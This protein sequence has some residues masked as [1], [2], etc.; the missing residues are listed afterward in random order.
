MSSSHSYLSPGGDRRDNS[1]AYS[2][3]R[4]LG[5][6][7]ETHLLPPQPVTPPLRVEGSDSIPTPS[8]PALLPSF[9]SPAVSRPPTNG[10]TSETEPLLS[11][12]DSRGDPNYGVYLSTNT[13][14][15]SRSP[16]L[17]ASRLVPVS[18]PPEEAAAALLMREGGEGRKR[19]EALL[20]VAAGGPGL[21]R[22]DKEE[23]AI[24]QLFKGFRAASQET[25][26][27]KI[28]EWVSLFFGI[29]ATLAPILLGSL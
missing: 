19:A 8:H 17:L 4:T 24:E 3:V 9:R 11:S 20:C 23:E 21:P 6:A 13:P 1:P 14:A 26:N 16:L 7:T 15:S 12:D 28:I 10:A 25:S 2:N 5:E 27:A 18:G 22:R 29:A